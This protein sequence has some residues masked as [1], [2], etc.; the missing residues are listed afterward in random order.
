[1]SKNASEKCRNL[2][3]EKEQQKFENLGPIRSADPKIHQHT[4]VFLR[5]KTQICTIFD[6]AVKS[7]SDCEKG[8]LISNFIYCGIHYFL[9]LDEREKFSS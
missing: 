7:I 5:Y 2:G 4:T 6:A 8:N 1:M 9:H 3:P